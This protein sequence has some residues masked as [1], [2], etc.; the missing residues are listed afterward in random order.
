MADLVRTNG[1]VARGNLHSIALGVATALTAIHDAGVVHR[2]LKP[3]N[4]LL[5]PGAPKVIDF[6]IATALDT[7]SQHTVP[8][9]VLGTIAYMGPERLNPATAANARP[10]ADVFA[11]GAIVTYAGTGHTPF[12]PEALIATA[13]GIALPPPDLTGLP[14]PLRDL[15]TRALHIDPAQRPSA[16]ELLELLLTTDTAAHAP[17]RAELARRPEL[18]KAASAV[19]HTVAIDTTEQTRGPRIHHSLRT[20]V[21]H[22]DHH[23]RRSPM[24]TIAV[25]A[26]LV[27]AAGLAAYSVAHTIDGG[28]TGNTP[29]AP[30]TPDVA[31]R[32]LDPGKEPASRGRPRNTC[33][34]D[35]PLQATLRNPRAFTCPTSDTPEQQSITARISLGTPEVCAA[36]WTHAVN[37]HGHRI[38]VCREHVSLEIENDG[39]S[40]TL[41][42]AALDEAAEPGTWH[43]VDIRAADTGVN[44]D[45]DGDRVVSRAWTLPAPACGTVT[46]GI[47]NRAHTARQSAQARVTV[48]DIAVISE[49]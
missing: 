48:A 28:G 19:R 36:I 7:T 5:A 29:A 16:H 26:A 44:V 20:L 14:D 18:R 23:A 22:R 4:V 49:P 42:H 37:G 27:V 24:R 15:V 39:N 34:L 12:A 10:S 35:G 46:L 13:A 38:T 1:P 40:R 33:I 47:V 11:W 17:I 3:A 32:N 25:A 2:D 21:S 41:A 43:R 8:G 30:A 31:E 6:G 9:Q 45:L